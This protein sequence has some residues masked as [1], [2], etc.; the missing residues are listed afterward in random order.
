V[1][2]GGVLPNTRESMVRWIMNPPE[3]DP[4]TAMPNLG[5]DESEARDIASFL[6]TL[7]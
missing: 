1:Y 3:V 6:Y 5:V 2:I 7:R 4:R